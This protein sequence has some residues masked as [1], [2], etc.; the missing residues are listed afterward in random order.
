M[1]FNSHIFIF[2]FLPITV[3]GYYLLARLSTTKAMVWLTAASFFF[4]AWWDVRYLVL[5]VFSIA[6]NYIVASYVANSDRYS[7]TSRHR[8]LIA[9]IVG[10]LVL[11]GYFKYANFLVDNANSV[12]GTEWTLQNIVLP[13][14][15]SFF[16]FQQI[17]YLVDAFR[18]REHESNV[19]RYAL[20]VTFFPQLI[21]GPI[22]HHKEML[23]QFVEAQKPS[24]IYRNLALGMTC[25]FIGL[26]KKT[27]IADGIAIYATGTFDGVAAGASIGFVDAWI[28]S[29]S[30]TFQM[31]FDFSGYSDMALGLAVMF[32]VRLP[33]N[34]A[35]PLKS[36]SML[37]FWRRWHI[38][39]GRFL[40]AYLFQPLSLIE[41]RKRWWSQPY[42]AF[43]ITMF[44]GG[45]WHGANWTFVVWGLMHG[46]LLAINQAWRVQKRK[47]GWAADSTMQRFLIGYPLTFLSVVITLTV[48]RSADIGTAG[49]MLSAMAGL[50]GIVMPERWSDT[51]FGGTMAALGVG[52]HP[53]VGLTA[54]PT[55]GL[56]FFVCF[57]IVWLLPCTY[58][59]FER[60]SIAIETY[61]LDTWW[62]ERWFVGWQ[63]NV[64]WILATFAIAVVAIDALNNISEFLY[65]QF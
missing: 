41:L 3:A 19:L 51:V 61:K 21:A 26:F 33:L 27:V 30:Y 13:L 32:G 2:L 36:A 55:L 31:Y 17:S 6:F 46:C 7:P 57:V 64:A 39:L 1:L 59:I 10:N 34:F 52:F 8:A 56:W 16:T 37:D 35:S 65:F 15:I 60:D 48:F 45:L 29:L 50:E 23:P 54:G 58:Q 44:L 25:F 53:E 43:I 62:G 4:Y 18:S 49:Q 28:A 40:Q 12:L 11:L 22:V 38:T 63:P 20:F 47:W 24:A 42:L 9:G 14:A 5:I